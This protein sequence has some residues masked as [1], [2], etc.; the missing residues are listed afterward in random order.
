MGIYSKLLIEKNL[1]Q[2]N[3]II[4]EKGLQRYIIIA[5]RSI[6][7]YM[8][9]EIVDEETLYDVSKNIADVVEDTREEVF[10]KLSHKRDYR[11]KGE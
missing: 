4:K 3:A 10:L 11:I 8:S 7:I 6:P 9:N 2:Y 5:D 1:R